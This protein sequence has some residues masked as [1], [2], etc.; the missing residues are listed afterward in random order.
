MEIT[1]LMSETENSMTDELDKDWKSFGIN[2]SIK[3]ISILNNVNFNHFK[4]P[5]AY[6]QNSGYF[7]KN[8][9][10]KSVKL[11]MSTQDMNSSELNST[12][13]WQ[14]YLWMEIAWLINLLS[15]LS[16]FKEHWNKSIFHFI[17]SLQ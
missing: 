5:A 13:D 12:L 6:H 3:F 8:L 1:S 9:V 7:K 2:E 16:T 10:L 15:K 4:N 11:L 17:I 14:K